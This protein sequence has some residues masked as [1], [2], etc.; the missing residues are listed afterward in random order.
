MLSLAVKSDS[1][2][3]WLLPALAPVLADYPIRLNLQVEDETRTQ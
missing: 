2:A 1:L 3:S